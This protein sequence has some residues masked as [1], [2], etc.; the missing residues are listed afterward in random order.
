MAA[1][2][3]VFLYISVIVIIIA[4]SL[5]LICLLFKLWNMTDDIKDIKNRLERAFPSNEENE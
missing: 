1:F 3:S 4:L 5:L 2:F